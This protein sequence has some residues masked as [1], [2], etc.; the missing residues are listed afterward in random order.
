MVK[1]IV[2]VNIAPEKTEKT[3]GSVKKLPEVKEAFQVYGEY[4][5]VFVINT[6]TT[7][8]IQEFVRKIRKMNGIMR[9]VTVIEMI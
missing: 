7:H 2:L 8:D 5:A 6:K 9:T 4:D 3:F 1:A